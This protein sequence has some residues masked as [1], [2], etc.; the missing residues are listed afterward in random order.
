MQ[1]QVQT[2]AG[3]V[4]VQL[5]DIRQQGNA[6]RRNG[7]S[8]NNLDLV[9]VGRSMLAHSGKSQCTPVTRLNDVKHNTYDE[10]YRI[11]GHCHACCKP[12]LRMLEKKGNH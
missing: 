3:L 6:R 5:R 12:L 4:H 8:L 7:G 9:K 11:S 1:V 10:V 2:G